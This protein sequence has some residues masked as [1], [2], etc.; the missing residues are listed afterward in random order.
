MRTL[1]CFL[2]CL[3][4][5]AAAEL[6]VPASVEFIR[7]IE[8]S[9]PD[10]QHLKLNLARP[11]DHAGGKL[12]AVICIH[13][14]GFRQGSRTSNDRRIVELASRGYVALTISYRLSPQYHFPAALQDSK[15]A[16]R[17]LRA[18]ASQYHVDPDRIGVIGGSAG[19]NL[20]LLL[21]TTGVVRDFDVGEHLD[22]SSAVA[23]VVSY[24]GA[25][26]FTRSYGASIGAG[27]TLPIYFGGDLSTK[28]REHILG[29]ALHWV[30]PKSAPTLC[31]HGA[32]DRNV[33]LEQ[34]VWIVERLQAAGVE[35][36]LLA[37]PQSAHA[38]NAEDRAR[39]ES[40]AFAFL[41]R[42]LK[43]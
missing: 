24:C 15:T 11:R 43:R 27:E 33:A 20:V 29:S 17:W 31:L 12:P 9:N 6:V 25:S 41:D 37:F 28:R 21:G 42:H 35:A 4:L 26:D 32:Q 30:T 38:F 23:C 1:V 40:A 7:D 10:N 19:G 22:Q 39:A 5:T 2:G 36:E 16:V 13:G 3:S 18:Q 14:G 34:S 8:F